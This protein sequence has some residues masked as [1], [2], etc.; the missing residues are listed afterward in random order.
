LLDK[1][2]IYISAKLLKSLYNKAFQVFTFVDAS[3]LIAKAN[4]WKERDQAIKEKYE[5]LNNETLPKVAY[6]KDAK[7]GCKGKDKFWYGFKKYTSVDMGSGLV[8][9][10]AITSANVSDAKGLKNVCP[11]QGAVFADKAYCTKQAK[12]IASKKSSFCIV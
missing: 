1:I 4:F 9:K 8:N 3:S 5:K 2:R 10:V 12:R 6:D 7:I 11:D